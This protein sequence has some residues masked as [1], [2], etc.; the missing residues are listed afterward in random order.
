MKY[1]FSILLIAF[2]LGETNAQTELW[3]YTYSGGIDNIGTIFKT[4]GNGNNYTVV[5]EF[6][7]ADQTKPSFY[8]GVTEVN[9]KLYGTTTQKGAYNWG[10]I[11]EFDIQT[12]E[13]TSVF[14]FDSVN[15]RNAQY[16][17]LLLA[18]D[19]MLYGMTTNGGI[20]DDG[21]I[22]KIDPN[23]KVF[24]KVF[25]FDDVV[26]GKS[27]HG[28]LI[29]ASNGDL[30]GIAFFG[31]ANSHGTIFKFNI[32][33]N[34]FTKLYD[35]IETSSGRGPQGRLLEISGKLYGTTRN[36]GIEGLGTL[37]EFDMSNLSVNVVH[38]FIFGAAEP[39][40]PSGTL[41]QASNGLL[42]GVS[43]YGG[44]SQNGS[45]FQYDLNS[46]TVSLLASFNNFV[47]GR[48]PWGALLEVENGVLYGMACYGGQFGLG[49]IYKYEIQTNQLIV[50]HT[51]AGEEYPGGNFIKASDSTLYAT[52]FSDDF[53]QAGKLFQ[54]DYI[55]DKF[56]AK[57]AFD[58]AI[59]GKNPQFSLTQ[60]GNGNFYGIISDLIFEFNPN[61]NVY[62]RKF[63]IGLSNN[64]NVYGRNPSGDLIPTSSGSYYGVA[65]DGGQYDKGVLFEYNPYTNDYTPKIYFNGTLG[66][67]PWSAPLPANNKYY[68]VTFRGGS[69]NSG[70][71][72]E[73][74]SITN[75][76]LLL[77][78]FDVTNS[79]SLPMYAPV[80]YNDTVLYGVTYNGG[81]N[82]FG[83]IYSYNLNNNTFTK[84]FDFDGANSGNVQN[85]GITLADNGKLYGLTARGGAN[86]LGVLFEYNISTST[87][88]K[89]LD[90]DGV[91]TGGNPSGFL[92]QAADGKLYG[93][94]T[95]G[96]ANNLGVTFN[97]DIL[98]GTYTILHNFDTLTGTKFA[99]FG[100]FT[101]VNACYPSTS[102]LNINECTSYTVP[103]GDETYTTIG[104]YVVL[105]TISN[106]CGSDSLL[107]IDLTI[108]G[109]SIYTDVQT[110]CDS[111]TW[112]DGNTYT[113]STNIPTV[114]LTTVNG[115]DSIVTLDLT[116][117]NSV[118]TTDV[119]VACDSYTWIDGNTY[120]SSTNTPTVTLT[121]V[122][123]CDSII[124]LDLTIYNSANT[125]DVQTACDSYTWIDGNT[126]TSSTNTPTVTLTTVNGCDSIITLDLTIYNS[127]NTTDVQ[128][129]CDSYTWI[130]GNTYTSSTNTPTVT[131]TTVNGC[132]SIVTLDLTINNS[133]NT[134][135]VQ[136]TCNSYTW[137]D[138]NTYTSSTNTP[139][140]TLTTV[141]GCDSIITLDLT[142]NSSN[143]TDVQTACD[144]YTWIDGNT[145]TSSTNIPT[146]TLTTVNGC[147]SIVTL[148]LT[149]YNSANTTD[150]Q[151]AC[152]PYTWIDGNTYT[153]STN[154]PTVTLTTVNGCDSIVTLDLTIYNSSNTTDVQTA[155]D[156]YT[157]IDGNT[158][159]SSTNTPTVTLTTVN[160][161]DSVVTLDL[162][163]NIVDVS[164]TTNAET[165]TANLIGATYQWLDCNNNYSIILGETSQAY[166]ATNDG[167][168]AVEITEN[169][170]IDTSFCVDVIIVGVDEL[171]G[172]YDIS[173]YPNP[174]QKMV[175][176][177]LDGIQNVDLTVL[178]VTGK[179]VFQEK[180]INK[181][182][183]TFEFTEKPG[184]YFIQLKFNE[185]IK[186]YKLIKK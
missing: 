77:Q 26:T 48:N 176:I 15:G 51:F 112:I 114:T 91:S 111:Y 131:L 19:G 43:E 137:I 101:E 18:N 29:Q 6:R 115:C 163:I 28:S 149:I 166:T 17:H 92:I 53:Y 141:N 32:T 84:L 14:D 95:S 146:V 99:T 175:N 119:Q 47:N 21:I 89:L 153:S 165:I 11:Y 143:T 69:S 152:D 186:V 78:S 116:I 162:T 121:T 150:V 3:G 126:Y 98:S 38:D 123:G 5:K 171:E 82:G 173:I 139:T 72:Y 161:C 45:I 138:G 164:I 40:T 12:E 157:W 172:D 147:D 159:T 184:V 81:V 127:A 65:K 63:I 23:T 79:G 71:L 74:D 75:T 46:G 9:G 155:C 2:V 61:T 104:N 135:D 151:T 35:F 85:C 87:Y 24:T 145:Y 102:N 76:I 120:T 36:G 67:E 103:S 57:I 8:G 13:Y 156:S 122:N 68:G 133:V 34:N 37:F 182:I 49:T 16:T 130:D 97:Y 10:G 55:N 177:G 80:S 129:G 110:G 66:D 132:D 86:N 169:S 136:I 42:Y 124:T 100:H 105:D 27:P 22:F 59:L 113:S 56:T 4:D 39:S 107:V 174:T 118:N 117:N 73:Y 33:T 1:I 94:T 128:T 83:V 20:N 54:Y 154:S 168:Y 140:V 41:V 178:D 44:A 179:K 109:S 108:M 183:Y 185:I 167:S 170:C 58:N 50:D 90:F 144:S 158:Y 62:K 70:V 134:T 31:G 106:T 60:S 93:G 125:T 96:G 88:T 180:E 64:S 148:D 25:D 181:N 30:Y 160:G 142:I 52:C 7:K